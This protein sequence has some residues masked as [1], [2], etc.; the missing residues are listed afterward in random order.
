MKMMMQFYGEAW[1][2]PASVSYKV[3]N[4]SVYFIS[5]SLLL[6]QDVITC[7]AEML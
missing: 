6:R 5:V 7:L 4:L 1:K 3:F 2:I